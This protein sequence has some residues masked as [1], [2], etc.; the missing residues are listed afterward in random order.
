MANAIVVQQNT[1]KMLEKCKEEFGATTYDQAIRELIKKAKKPG[2]TMQGNLKVN[3][4][5][6]ETQALND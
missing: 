5:V 3:N 4:V 6:K 1:L 2:I